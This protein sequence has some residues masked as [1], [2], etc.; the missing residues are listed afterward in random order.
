MPGPELRISKLIMEGFPCVPFHIYFTWYVRIVAQ[1]SPVKSTWSSNIT[2]ETHI[3]R[4]GEAGS[5][6]FNGTSIPFR[7]KVAGRMA[8]T[9]LVVRT[10]SRHGRGVQC[11]NTWET[12]VPG[13]TLQG[14]KLLDTVGTNLVSM[15]SKHQTF[16]VMCGTGWTIR[17]TLIWSM[18]K[19]LPSVV[20]RFQHALCVARSMRFMLIPAA[21]LLGLLYPGHRR[22]K[23]GRLKRIPKEWILIELIVSQKRHGDS[24]ALFSVF[25]S[26]SSGVSVC[27]FSRGILRLPHFLGFGICHL[28]A[29]QRNKGSREAP[30]KKYVQTSNVSRRFIPGILSPF[31]MFFA[32]ILQPP[33]QRFLCTACRFQKK[34]FEKPVSDLGVDFCQPTRFSVR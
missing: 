1:K 15:V 23:K 4:K 20:F 33:V 6:H 8:N 24:Q 10:P 5:H 12:Q 21:C 13:A 27:D 17:T 14:L 31:S 19:K 22:T 28:H 16:M 7:S 11:Y 9:P 32:R 3:P 2:T 25:V 34:S 18:S 29:T 30:K 26:C